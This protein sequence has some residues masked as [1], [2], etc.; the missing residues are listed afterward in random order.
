MRHITLLTDFGTREGEHTVMKGVIWNIVP[1]NPVADL[2]HDIGPQNIRE[3]A[4][5][6]ERTAHFFPDETVHI[7]VVDPGVGTHRRA[8]AAQFGKHF[9]VGPD[10]GVC[11]PMLE[12]AES[13]GQPVK[14]VDLDKPEFWLENVSPIFHGRDIFAPAG[15][16]LARGAALAD[17]GTIITNPVRFHV[18]KPT[19]IN[20]VLQ[21]EVMH[22]DHFGNLICNIHHRDLSHLEAFKIVLG[23]VE[24]P[25]MSLTFGDREVG[26]LVAL[27]SPTDYLMIAVTNGS[28]R[29]KLGSAVGDL[30]EVRPAKD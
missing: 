22:I 30:V 27:F 13:L 6:L 16:H 2:S 18:P 12:R 4:L 14:I 8:I 1:G 21:G 17:M 23:E 15:G 29:E 20:G 25:E 10:N 7:V 3:A 5:V 28:A 19:T 9:F 11:T 26:E 24:F